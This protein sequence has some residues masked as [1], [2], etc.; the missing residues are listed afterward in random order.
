M[1]VRERYDFP[2]AREKFPYE[3]W[4]RGPNRKH[5]DSGN[6]IRKAYILTRPL[7]Q[8]IHVSLGLLNLIL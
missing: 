2:T 1:V 5:N 8:I 4:F 7:S 3:K 6:P